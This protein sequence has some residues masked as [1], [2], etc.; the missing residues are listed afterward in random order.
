LDPNAEPSI[1]WVNDVEDPFYPLP[2]ETLMLN[3]RDD[4]ERIDIFLDKLIQMYYVEHR[5]NLP[6]QTC[7]GSAISSCQ[8][9]LEKSGGRIVAFSS[10]GCTRGVGSLKSRD[11]VLEY[12]TSDELNLFKH[13]KEHDFYVKLGQK[14]VEKHIAVDLYLG[15]STNLESHDL[16]S[17]SKVVNLTGGDFLY[18]SKFDAASHGE[19]LYYELFRNISKAKAMDVQIKA[20]C[21]KGLSII[22]YFGGF[23]AFETTEFAISS[24]D[25]DKSFGF[26]LRNDETFD[27][28]RTVYI[29]IAMLYYD[30]YGERRIR[31]FNHSFQVV[32]S[33]NTYFKATVV[34][35]YAQYFLRQKLARIEQKG[36]KNIR[37]EII[38]KLVDLLVAYRTQCAPNSSPS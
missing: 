5:R 25:A 35:S 4:R 10:N 32:K 37:E 29:Q 3:V 12:N 22:E 11:K 21:S 16:A 34:E 33:L 9:L 7:L 30:M 6:I 36:A 23:G 19:K 18:F 31:V 27:E 28:N 17:L 38:N 1:L 15:V 24:F 20:R 13:T 2:L 26:T 14:C 8:Q